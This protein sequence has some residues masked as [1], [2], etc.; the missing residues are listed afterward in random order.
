[1]ASCPY[2]LKRFSRHDNLK[3]HVVRHRKSPP[4]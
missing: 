2:C 1:L 3:R 4:E